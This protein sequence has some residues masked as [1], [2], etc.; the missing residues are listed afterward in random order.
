MPY[1]RPEQY[2]S[3]S[4]DQ[5]VYPVESYARDGSENSGKGQLRSSAT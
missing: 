5:I 1:P 4:G 2:G 3:T